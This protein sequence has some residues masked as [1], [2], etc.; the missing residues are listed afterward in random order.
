MNPQVAIRR[1]VAALVLFALARGSLRADNLPL[2]P[3]EARTPE[4]R[5]LTDVE[6]DLAMQRDWLFQAMGEP[7]LSRSAHEIGWARELAA[8]LIRQSP[9]LDLSAELQELSALEE[10]LAALRDQSSP[11]KRG[12]NSVAIPSWIWYPE[13]QPVADAPAAA[14]F[15][16]QRFQLPDDV[17]AAV[18]RVAADDAC[19]V[20]INGTRVGSHD[21]W[22]RAGV[23]DIG[24]VLAPR[25]VVRCPTNTLLLQTARRKELSSLSD[26]HRWFGS[27]AA[28]R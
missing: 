15:F 11:V 3:G 17:H 24:K 1:F 7:L 27:T 26:E 4:T 28:H 20:F 2:P 9:V 23:F 18:L 12:S 13:G 25:L 22:Q 16:R 19:E 5:S 10:R 14:R 8:R 6:S 21:T